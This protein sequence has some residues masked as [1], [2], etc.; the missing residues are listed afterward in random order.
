MTQ[1]TMLHRLPTL[2]D[3]AD[4]AVFVASDRAAA[5]TGAMLNLSCGNFVD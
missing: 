2:R 5:M 4:G 3:L 1:G